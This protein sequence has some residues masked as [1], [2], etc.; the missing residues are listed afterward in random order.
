MVD[1]DV[2]VLDWPPCSPD[3]NPI[4]N[5]WRD[6]KVAANAHHPRDG[7]ELW[8]AV[9]AAWTE[10]PGDRM[11]TLVESVAVV[12]T[13]NT[14][15]KLDVATKPGFFKSQKQSQRD[16]SLFLCHT[17]THSF[18]R[19]GRLLLLKQHFTSYCPIVT[20]HRWPFV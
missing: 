14:E 15:R 20:I 17:P 18:Q 6:L 9:Q 7:E 13:P 1:N 19:T 16:Q 12:E 11:R 5:L 4:E 2:T 10:I 8:A 3:V